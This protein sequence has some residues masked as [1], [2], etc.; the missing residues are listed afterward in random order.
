[1]ASPFAYFRRNQRILMAVAGVTA[2]VAFVFVDPITQL[3]T[4]SRAVDDPV[5]V[6][7]DYGNFRRSD[8]DGMVQ[9]RLVVAKFLQRAAIA[10]AQKILMQEQ[11][12]GINPQMVADNLYQRW[13]RAFM[14]RIRPAGEA[15]AVETLVLS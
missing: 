7:T 14:G 5:V 4:S 3:V 11:R 15:A 13:Q 1:M 12:Q 10:L 6:K 2:I 8:L 9:S